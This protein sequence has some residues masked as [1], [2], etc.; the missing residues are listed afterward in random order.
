MQEVRNRS[1]RVTINRISVPRPHDVLA[2]HLRDRILNGEMAEGDPLPSEREL[3]E[4][5][6]LTRGAVR[7][8]LRTL[9][10]EGLVQTKHGRFGGSVVT[11]PGHDSMAMAISRFVQGRKVP[12]RVLQETRETLEPYLARWAAERRTDADVEELKEIHAALVS[13]IENF[14]EFS[15]LNVKWHM[16]IARASGNEL[17]A[18]LLRSISQGVL[19]ATTAEEYNSVETGKEVIAIHARI[20][21]AIEARDPDAAERRMR[22]H[23]V[24]TN[25]RPIAIAEETI[26]LTQEKPVRKK[27]SPTVARRVRN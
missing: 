17:L 19:I 25:A 11:L 6:G 14:Q 21:D 3:V 15:L 24:A 5:T 13:S 7:Q 20:L 26:A 8:A 23:M 16:A 27:A 2:N 22:Q 10:V 18:T 12:L 1:Q 4:Q 9:W